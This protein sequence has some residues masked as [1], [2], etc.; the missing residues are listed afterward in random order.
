MLLLPS[1]TF[2][3]S[4]ASAAPWEG[5]NAF[6]AAHLAYANIAALRQQI[7]PDHRVHGVIVGPGDLAANGNLNSIPPHLH[8][9]IS[10]CLP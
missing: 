1:L 3:R 4:Q 6:D 10:I 7:K 9:L 8:L 5:V 2:L